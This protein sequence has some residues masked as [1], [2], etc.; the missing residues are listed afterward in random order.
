MSLDKSAVEERNVLIYAFS[1]PIKNAGLCFS[2]F[3]V[4]WEI[5]V[6]V[7]WC[8]S[9]VIGFVYKIGAIDLNFS[10]TLIKA[11]PTIAYFF[12]LSFTY[13]ESQWLT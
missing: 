1:Q 4:G 13:L 9:Y 8:C 5:E 6:F 12:G 11:L 10:E 7:S 3:L 2:V